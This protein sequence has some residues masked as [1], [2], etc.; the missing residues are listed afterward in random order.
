MR[1]QESASAGVALSNKEWY[2]TIHN[3]IYHNAW[4]S[5]VISET[6]ALASPNS[7]EVL[8]S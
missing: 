2:Y 3:T 1:A 8:G 7:N 6:D 4:T 5:E